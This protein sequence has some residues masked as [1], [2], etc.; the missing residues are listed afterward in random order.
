[1]E[2]VNATRTCR[3]IKVMKARYSGFNGRYGFTPT[4][5][6]PTGSGRLTTVRGN[7]TAVSGVSGPNGPGSNAP[8]NSS[9]NPVTSSAR[10][11]A[12]TR[13]I[14]VPGST[15]GAVNPGM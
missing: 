13:P 7:T 11:E 3:P 9:R 12:I 8:G 15:P 6:T 14:T 1:M 2:S 4:T 5:S 10:P